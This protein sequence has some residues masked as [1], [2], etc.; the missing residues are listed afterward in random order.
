IKDDSRLKTEDPTLQPS[1]IEIRASVTPRQHVRL[2]GEDM[3]A[4][5]LVLPANH[6]LRPVD[7]GALAGCGHTEVRVYRRPRVAVIPTGTELVP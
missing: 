5:E 2:M 4:T 1:A 6:T 7:I 3:V